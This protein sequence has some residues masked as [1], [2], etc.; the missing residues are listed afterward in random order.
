MKKTK[1]IKLAT[2]QFH[3]NAAWQYSFTS[4][5]AFRPVAPHASHPPRL[6]RLQDWHWLLGIP[7][8]N[9]GNHG[10]EHHLWLGELSVDSILFN[11]QKVTSIVWDLVYTIWKG[12]KVKPLLIVPHTV[13]PQKMWLDPPAAT[14][15]H[16]IPKLLFPSWPTGWFANFGPHQLPKHTVQIQTFH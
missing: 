3:C 14:S 12:R 15:T 8:V 6:H 10:W 11:Y 1:P 13:L 16:R 2:R 9:G 4:S 5:R 7:E